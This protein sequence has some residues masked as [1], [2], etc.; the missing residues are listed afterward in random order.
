M[1][2]VLPADVFRR[3]FVEQPR[4]LALLAL[5]ASFLMTQMW[6]M[7]SQLGEATRKTVLVQATAVLQAIVHLALVAMAVPSGTLCPTASFSPLIVIV[8]R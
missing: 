6:G 1:G 3:I 2:L 8:V 7:V 5:G 4:E